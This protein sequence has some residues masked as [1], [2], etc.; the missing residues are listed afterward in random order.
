MRVTTTTRIGCPPQ[1]VFDTLADMRNET[2]WNN[3]VSNAELE[4]AEPIGA[5][6]RFTIVNGGT[7]Y[8]ANIAVYEP[9]SRLVIEANGKPDLTIAYTFTAAG[10]GTKL[11]SDFEFR[12]KGALKIV[13]MLLTPVIRR[14]VSKQYA[15]LKALCEG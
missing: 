3:R 5:G 13:F 11:E 9:P 7:S 12:P 14:D 1:Q 8:D 4:S 6:A 10:E 15:S 2:R